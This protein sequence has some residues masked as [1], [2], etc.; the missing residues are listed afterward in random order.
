VRN[1]RVAIVGAGMSGLLMGVR[2]RQAGYSDFTIFEKAD[3]IGGTWR[4]NRYPGL[5]CDI[6]SRYYS[7]SFAHNPGWSRVFAPGPEIL[8]YLGEV[9]DRHG[10]REHIRLG[11]E[12]TSGRF[13]D[14][15]WH[16]QTNR[17]HEEAFDFLV[18]ACGILHHPRVP[19]IDGLEDFAGSCFHTARWDHGVTLAG[20]RVGIIGNGSTGAQIVAAIAAEVA[21]LDVFQ[22]TPQWVLPFPNARYTRLGRNVVGRSRRLSQLGYHYY[23][24]LYERVLTRGMIEPGWQR[25]LMSWICRQ[26]LRVVRDPELRRRLTPDYQPMCKRIIVSAGFYRAMNRPNVEL[27]TT[28]IDRVEAEGVVTS[29]GALHGLDMLLLATGFDSHAFMRPMELIGTGGLTL[30]QAWS[31]DPRAYQTVALPGFPNFFL[32]VGPHSPYGNQS[33]IMISE[34]QVNYVMQWIS[35]WAAGEVDQMAPTQAATDR[36]NREVREA[37][38]AT[39]WVTGCNSWYLDSEGVPELWP[40][41]QDRHRRLL[42]EPEPADFELVAS[43]S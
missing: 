19:P 28:P 25:R 39:I 20:K 40:W 42:A 4:D 16:V 21:H 15:R 13:E 41:R 29:D 36:F 43:P 6:P 17:G 2:L 23:R 3:A 8:R 34:T 14:G 27:V 5:V 1:P 26:H 18:S 11:T 37:M 32:L 9:A 38:P 24:A 35:R 30:S 33:V 22:R 10:L 12:V 31:K 7:Y